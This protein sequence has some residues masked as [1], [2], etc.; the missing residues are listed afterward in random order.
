MKAVG[1]NWHATKST[2]TA[3]LAPSKVAQASNTVIEKSISTRGSGSE[4]PVVSVSKPPPNFACSNVLCRPK[5]ASS[6]LLP[7]AI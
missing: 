6:N 2:A 3:N 5:R 4:S 7:P 1:P